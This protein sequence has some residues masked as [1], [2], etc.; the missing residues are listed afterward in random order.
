M[1]PLPLLDI[2]RNVYLGQSG[3]QILPTHG[4]IA[5]GIKGSPDLSHFIFEIKVGKRRIRHT[6][7][8][9]LNDE[10]LEGFKINP[11]RRHSGSESF[12]LVSAPF[13]Q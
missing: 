13:Q 2:N 7:I 10:F 9:K 1:V 3:N 12:Y 8:L 6:T 4:Q 11:M 5:L